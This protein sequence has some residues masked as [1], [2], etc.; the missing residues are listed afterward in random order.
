MA[1]LLPSMVSKPSLSD[2]LYFDKIQNGAVL[3]GLRQFAK[4]QKNIQS[5]V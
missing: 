3:A 2:I 5:I 4:A 1:S